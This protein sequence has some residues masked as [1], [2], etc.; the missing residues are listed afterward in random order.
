MYAY[1]CCPS[2]EHFQALDAFYDTLQ[3]LDV[4]LVPDIHTMRSVVSY[5]SP[6]ERESFQSKSYHKLI[7]PR[8]KVRCSILFGFFGL[9]QGGMQRWKVDASSSML[10][11]R[12]LCI[13]LA[14]C[15]CIRT[16][17]HI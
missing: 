15:T 10:S 14:R 5:L 11:S 13:Q 8:K 12:S 2:L 9:S 6:E 1:T 4:Q 17:I 3:R 7:C 16:C